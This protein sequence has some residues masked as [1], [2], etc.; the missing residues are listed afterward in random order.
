M[1]ED[2]QPDPDLLKRGL[3]YCEP[4]DAMSKKLAQFPSKA[5][6]SR[7]SGLRHPI[8]ARLGEGMCPL[9]VCHE[10]SYPFPIL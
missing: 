8:R 5:K 7:P 2:T 4:P 10:V 6:A 3:S 9:R 1:N